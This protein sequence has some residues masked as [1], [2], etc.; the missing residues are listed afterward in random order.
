GAAAAAPPDEGAL[1]LGAGAG[2]AGLGAGAGAAAV[3]AVVAGRFAQP[4]ITSP[5]S[6]SDNIV[7]CAARVTMVPPLTFT[8]V[9]SA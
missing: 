9:T 5:A 7:T 3:D 6:S 4:V 1:D 8:P 2:P